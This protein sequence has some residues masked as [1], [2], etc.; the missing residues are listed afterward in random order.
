VATLSQFRKSFIFTVFEI[1]NRINFATPQKKILKMLF[2]IPMYKNRYCRMGNHK[3]SNLD[4]KNLMKE[5][6]RSTLK[7]R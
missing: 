3:Q 1:C 7:I 5:Y 6:D 2:I 4:E